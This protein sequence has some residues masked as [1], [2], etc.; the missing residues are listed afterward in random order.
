MDF[1][2][3]L[4][5]YLIV[6]GKSISQWEHHIHSIKGCDAIRPALNCFV[7]MMI[8]VDT[9]CGFAPLRLRRF[10]Q[11]WICNVRVT[12][13]DTGFLKGGGGPTNC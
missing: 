11:S 12:G 8:S 4:T 6:N 13:A 3:F 9:L 10:P 5:I 2:D 7:L 1:D